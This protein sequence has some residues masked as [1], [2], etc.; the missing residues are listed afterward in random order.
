MSLP[1]FRSLAVPLDPH[2]FP[3]PTYLSQ[4]TSA[5]L[6]SHR[7]ISCHRRLVPRRIC[8]H[9][10]V[11]PVPTRFHAWQTHQCS[12]HSTHS[13]RSPHWMIEVPPT[14]EWKTPLPR[15]DPTSLS[16]QE[17]NSHVGLRLVP[18]MCRG[19]RPTI[20]LPTGPSPIVRIVPTGL[21]TPPTVVYSRS[22]PRHVG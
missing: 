11:S 6:F 10:E 7:G 18:R 3:D 20:G 13:A 21:S 12:T 14:S 17:V 15:G 1:R 22:C 8:P 19:A 5:F 16:Q 2:R 9:T 4:P